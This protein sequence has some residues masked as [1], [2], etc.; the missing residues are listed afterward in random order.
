MS[1][2]P[3]WPSGRLNNL[4]QLVIA[5]YVGRENGFATLWAIIAWLA[6]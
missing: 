1:R 2:H 4:L 3:L 6:I 5:F